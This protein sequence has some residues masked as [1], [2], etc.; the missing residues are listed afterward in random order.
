MSFVDDVGKE[1]ERNS[2]VRAA[3][4]THAAD[5]QAARAAGKPLNA[6]YRTLKRKGHPVG[7]GYSSFRN[8]VRYLDEHG[9]PGAA[10]MVSPE[11]SPIPAPEPSP[12]PALRPTAQPVTEQAARDRFADNRFDSDF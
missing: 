8:A 2:P 3:V 10:A 5:I 4:K 9:W 12:I 7:K 1:Q 6:V 11:P